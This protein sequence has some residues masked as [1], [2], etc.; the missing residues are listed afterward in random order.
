MTINESRDGKSVKLKI[1]HRMTPSRNRLVA[2]PL[3]YESILSNLTPTE[4]VRR[5]VVLLAALSFL[6]L[7]FQINTDGVNFL[8][9]QLP[10]EVLYFAI[11]HAL[12]FYLVALASHG[13]LVAA[14]IVGNATTR[15][16]ERAEV[17]SDLA[18]DD[19]RVIMRAHELSYSNPDPEVLID[20]AISR[21]NSAIDI[22]RIEQQHLVA[23]PK[24]TK[25]DE[26]RIHQIDIDIAREEQAFRA[27]YGLHIATPRLSEEERHK[28]RVMDAKLSLRQEAEATGNVPA[29]GMAYLV[30]GEWGFPLTFASFCLVRL[31]SSG[32]FVPVWRLN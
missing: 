22:L 4:K 10:R 1:G 11:F 24:R 30:L 21:L 5:N 27:D 23:K 19:P 32:H 26:A 28:K 14:H 31:Y 2:A 3:S 20:S 13:I 7:N 17:L 12:F 9:A 18:D 25:N 15:A 16:R 8:G 29:V 6:L